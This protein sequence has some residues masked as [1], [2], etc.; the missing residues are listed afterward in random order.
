M[1][2]YW[3][4]LCLDIVLHLASYIMFFL[5]NDICQTTVGGCQ[6]DWNRAANKS[7]YFLKPVDDLHYRQPA[8]LL[9]SKAQPRKDPQWVHTGA[10]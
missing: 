9:T 7:A 10:A 1:Q 8:C 6:E 2:L 3:Q 5:T 4:N